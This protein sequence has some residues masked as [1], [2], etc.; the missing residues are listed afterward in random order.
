MKN[1]KYII[2]VL[3]LMLMI[4]SN[5]VNAATHECDYGSKM[6]IIFDESGTAEVKQSYYEDKKMPSLINA[7][8]NNTSGK[9]TSTDNLEFQVKELFGACPSNLYVCKYEEASSESGLAS[10][11][12]D[13]H[14]LVN[15]LNKVYIFY[16]E[17]EMNENSELKDL[18]NGE[19][20]YGSEF[21]DSI[22]DGYDACSGYDIAVLEQIT[23]ALCA[24]GN[25]LITSGKSLWTAENFYIKYK[26][27][28]NLDY[29]GTGPTYNLACPN[30]NVF[31]G[32]F[33]TAITNYKKCNETDAGCLSHTITQVEKEETMIKDYCKA[34]LAHHNYDGGNEQD[35]IQ[36]CLDIGDNL[37]KAKK[38]A[39][40]LS[41]ESGDCGFSARLLVWVSNILR[42]IKY[43]LPVAVIV[44]GIL[45]FIK[46]IGSDKDDEMKKAQG[47]FIRRLI[48]AALVFLIPLIIEFILDKM[49]F[50]YNDCSIF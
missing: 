39:G 46:A 44:L 4:G 20:E 14:G 28:F 37:Q 23:G 27:C 10:W 35:C 49:G 47:K 30:L 32:R 41:E 31:L 7:F 3:V 8:Y 43:I 1:F 19:V 42:W 11:F 13:E 25:F 38:E 2:I 12:S 22:G 15:F 24:A 29:Q 50:G 9:I 5:N 16:S 33:N 26:N 18:P 21:L 17:G 45:D 40:L 36:A 48:A 34:I 6:K